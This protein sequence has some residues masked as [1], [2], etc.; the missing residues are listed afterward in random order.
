MT[1]RF[2]RVILLANRA[3]LLGNASRSTKF[4]LTKA[5]TCQSRKITTTTVAREQYLHGYKDNERYHGIKPRKL[6]Q[7]KMVN[8]IYYY[9]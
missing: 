1:S 8:N 9:S 3:S 5:V 4:Q 2:G 7:I 6:F